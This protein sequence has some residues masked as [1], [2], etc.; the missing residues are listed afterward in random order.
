MDSVFEKILDYSSWW[1][2]NKLLI[3][4]QINTGLVKVIKDDK[5]NNQSAKLDA[6]ELLL[7]KHSI[8]RWR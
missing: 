6:I 2:V 5:K 7:S 8:A 4:S 1:D 3:A